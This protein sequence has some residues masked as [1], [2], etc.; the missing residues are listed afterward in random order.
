M[1]EKAK[2][3]LLKNKV[4]GQVVFDLEGDDL[5]NDNALEEIYIKVTDRFGGRPTYQK[6]VSV[7]EADEQGTIY[8]KDFESGSEST[9]NVNRGEIEKLLKDIDS[10]WGL[11]TP[12]SQFLMYVRHGDDVWTND[13]NEGVSTQNR[14]GNGE[15]SP[16][17]QDVYN[18]TVTS[19]LSFEG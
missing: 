18:D 16:L 10:I 1:E 7:E 2:Y 13:P 14:E 15:F 12:H 8:S 3:L 17:Q 11:P 19:I 6:V 5:L 9:R 4:G